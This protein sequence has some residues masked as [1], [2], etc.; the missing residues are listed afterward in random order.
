ML[1][2]LVQILEHLQQSI[3]DWGSLGIFAF[4]GIFVLAQM[5]MVPV[6][7]LA[8]AFGLFFG[9]VQ[10]SLG[11]MLGCAIGA[12]INFLISRHLARKAVSRW[13]GAHE[14]FRMIDRA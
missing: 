7:P 2:H 9:F 4:A 8:M 3:H 1:D 5:I 14:K 6:A 13:L 10:G 12:S 11:L